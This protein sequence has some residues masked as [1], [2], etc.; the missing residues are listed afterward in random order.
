MK[1]REKNAHM[2]WC[3]SVAF[4]VGKLFWSELKW[5][6]LREISEKVFIL[7]FEVLVNKFAVFV[8]FSIW[9]SRLSIIFCFFLPSRQCWR[10]QQRSKHQ[11]RTCRSHWTSK[12]TATHKQRQLFKRKLSISKCKWKQHHIHSF[13][14]SLCSSSPTSCSRFEM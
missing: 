1:F 4:F 5:H 10:C 2:V 9:L 12:I 6:K 11:R 14:T 13:N 7:F 3:R 8:P